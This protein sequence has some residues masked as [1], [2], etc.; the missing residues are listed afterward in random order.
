VSS[1]AGWYPDPGGQR[2]AFRYWNGST[3]SA[4]LSSTQTAPPPSGGLGQPSSGAPQFGQYGY[5][6]GMGYAPQ[7]QRKRNV[8]LWIGIVVG[9]LVVALIGYG[10]FRVASQGGLTNTGGGTA[11]GNSTANV[12]PKNT[13]SLAPFNHTKDGRVHGGMLSFPTLSPPWEAPVPDN[14]VPF[15]RDV[16]VQ[17]AMV[18]ASYNGTNSWVASVLVAELAA[19]DGFFSPQEGSEI[20][21]KC[22][23]GAFY[24]DAVVTRDDKVN[25]AT[26]VGGKD[27]WLVET[28]L[29]FDIPKLKT[30]GETAIVLIVAT[31][32]EASSL[33][34]ASIPD[35]SPQYMQPARDSMAALQVGN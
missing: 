5:Q 24:A 25:K 35:T 27:A 34:Y 26:T 22:L 3:W 30:K 19:G 23:I 33:F 21:V 16:T 7:P 12:C 18:E 31:S 10:V 13:Q 9:V 2:G 8:G 11:G 6:P 1:P 28:H 4:Q 32:T 17:N 14:R 15:G 20:V 29:T